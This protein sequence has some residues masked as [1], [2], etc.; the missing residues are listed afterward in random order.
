MAVSTNDNGRLSSGVLLTG[1]TG[2]LG[3]QLLALFITKLPP[4][5]PIFCLIRGSKNDPDGPQTAQ[6]RLG[7]LLG[8]M[9]FGRLDSPEV[10]RVQ[11]VDGDLCEEELGLSTTDH[12]TL[13]SQVGYI[14]HGAASVRFD[15]PLATARQINVEG[16]RRV[17]ELAQQMVGPTKRPRF[18][19]IGT[20]FVAGTQAGLVLEDDLRPD[21]PFHNTYE[22]TKAEAE[23]LV[24]QAFSNPGLA[25]TLFRPSII[26]GDSR[27]GA[28]SSFK[29]MYWPLKVF[30]RGL[31]PI[32]PASRDGIVDLVPVDFVAA[33]IF[34]LALRDD[35]DRK[36]FHLAAGPQGNMTIGEALQLAAAFFRV[37]KPWFVKTEIFEQCI[38]PVFRLLFFGKRRK[39]LDAGRVYVPYLNYRAVFDTTNLQAALA[40]TGL[41]APDVRTYFHRLLRYC[42]DSDWGNRSV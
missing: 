11:A 24:R 41:V 20:A 27:T 26:V 18:A 19:Y 37:R 31:F 6:G 38:R 5:T 1:A 30:S 10:A 13:V 15:L 21:L 2:F 25:V 39:A 9:G 17:L 34:V 23:Q 28:T 7:A 40:E 12:A 22:Q 32:V 16:T 29:V 3:R 42:V 35:T 4:D 8:Q 14:F 36:C 33:A